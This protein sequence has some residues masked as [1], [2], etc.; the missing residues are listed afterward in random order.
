MG[1]LLLLA[2]SQTH[3]SGLALRC[4]V[5]FAISTRKLERFVEVSDWLWIAG[6]VMQNENTGKPD[7]LPSLGDLGC[8]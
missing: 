7:D 5:A 2:W 3:V 4:N 1:W 6:D 8:I